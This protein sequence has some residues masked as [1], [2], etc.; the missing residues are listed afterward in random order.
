MLSSGLLC[1]QGLD[2]AQRRPRGRAQDGRWRA[3]A[4]GQGAHRRSGGLAG[5]AP[6]VDQFLVHLDP[7]PGQGVAVTA[8]AGGRGR[9]GGRVAD[10][11]RAPVPVGDEVSHGVEGRAMVIDPDQVRRE[12]RRLPV[13]EH[14]GDPERA[15]PGVVIAWSGQS[16][17]PATRRCV[18]RPMTRRDMGTLACPRPRRDRLPPRGAARPRPVRAGGLPAGRR[19][20]PQPGPDGRPLRR[21]R[22]GQPPPSWATRWAGCSRLARSSAAAGRI[23]SLVI[24]G[25]NPRSRFPVPR[26]GCRYPS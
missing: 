16:S 3:G 21:P 4:A 26:S 24:I 20:R 14:D 13:H 15:E 12:A 7:V 1:A 2:H 23:A 10:A 17:S 8:Q 9:D 22:A 25:G 6:A 11:D 5:G 19:A 18:M